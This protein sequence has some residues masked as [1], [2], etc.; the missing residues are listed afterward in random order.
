[1]KQENKQIM[2]VMGMILGILAILIPMVLAM[3]ANNQKVNDIEKRLDTKDI[4]DTKRINNLDDR[5]IVLE[6]I[7][8]G[9]EVSLTVIKS[10]IGEIKEDLKQL[11]RDL[12]DN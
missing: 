8:A 11:S 6:K 5:V 10:D 7:A 1:M 2:K 4:L 9:S 12:R 3:G